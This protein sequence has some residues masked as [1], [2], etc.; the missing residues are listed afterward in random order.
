MWQRQEVQAL[1]RQAGLS[2]GVWRMLLY[3]I[4]GIYPRP[5]GVARFGGRLG[6]WW[7]LQYIL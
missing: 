1:S 5:D 7:T 3:W 6:G 4:A 2:F